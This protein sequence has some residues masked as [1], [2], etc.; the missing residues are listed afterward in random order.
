MSP[1]PETPWGR[2]PAP[3]RCGGTRWPWAPDFGTLSGYLFCLSRRETDRLCARESDTLG[4]QR[5][6][7]PLSSPQFPVPV[8]AASQT[9]L[10]QVLGNNRAGSAP[11]ALPSRPHDL[12][13]TNPPFPDPVLRRGRERVRLPGTTGQT[14]RPGSHN[15]GPEPGGGTLPLPPQGRPPDASTDNASCRL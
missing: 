8:Q 13:G 15:S 10:P 7:K 4:D 5:G 9:A 1:P 14:T 12:E 6:K 11:R 3:L 2:V